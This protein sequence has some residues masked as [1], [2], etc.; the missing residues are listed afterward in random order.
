MWEHFWIH[1]QAILRIFFFDIFSPCNNYP[2][3]NGLFIWIIIRF[4]TPPIPQYPPHL[5]Y[6]TPPIPQYPPHLPYPT[7]P[8]P[9]IPTPPYPRKC[10]FAPPPPLLGGRRRPAGGVV[11]Q[12]HIFWGMGGGDIGVLGGRGF[13]NHSPRLLIPQQGIIVIATGITTI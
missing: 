10:G 11:V 7:P 4:P 2:H 5:P 12:I 1:P 8:Y 9:N 3:S 13:I 6:P